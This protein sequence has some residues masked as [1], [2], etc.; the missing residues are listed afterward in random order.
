MARLDHQEL[1]ASAGRRVWLGKIVKTACLSSIAAAGGLYIQFSNPEQKA[2]G[3]A[4]LG[5]GSLDLLRLLIRDTQMS[6]R[7][8]VDEDILLSDIDT[9]LSQ[10]DTALR[11]EIGQLFILLRLYPV[12]VMAGIQNA[13]VKSVEHPYLFLEQL[14]GSKVAHLRVA[15]RFLVSVIQLHLYK[16][17][18]AWPDS[19]QGLP[20]QVVAYR[21][22]HA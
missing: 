14:R 2:F 15:Y 17:S 4:F 5:E 6:S 20:Q 8:K 9:H 13:S 7:S 3:R 1:S 11:K 16:Y 21:A 12:K 10:L 19:F 22:E 18:E